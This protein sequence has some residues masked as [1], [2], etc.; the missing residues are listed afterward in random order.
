MVKRA[1]RWLGVEQITYQ[2]SPVSLSRVPGCEGR[3]GVD[4]RVRRCLPVLARENWLEEELRHNV[5]CVLGQRS[6]VRLPTAA[7]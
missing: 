4:G 7:S 2:A 3:D 6:S 1:S 5:R